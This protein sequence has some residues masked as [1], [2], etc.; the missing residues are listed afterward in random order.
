MLRALT[1][2]VLVTLPFTLT[3]CD[4]SSSNGGSNPVTQVR[5]TGASLID[6][7]FT[8]PDGSDWDG[9]T[10]GGPDVYLKIL[11]NDV[12]VRNTQDD[13]DLDNLTVTDLPRTFNFGSP[14]VLSNL[15]QTLKIEVWD[16]DG[17]TDERIAEFAPVPIQTIASTANPTYNLTDGTTSVRLTLAYTR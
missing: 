6:L 5:I 17:S 1:L 15:S 14:Q 4:S 2:A 7:A 11:I 3:A 12:E 10:A 16:D 9:L 8:R 13:D